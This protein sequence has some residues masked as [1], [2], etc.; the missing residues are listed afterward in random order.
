MKGSHIEGAVCI[1][2][3]QPDKFV[4]DQILLKQ[5]ELLIDNEQSQSGALESSL[6]DHEI[7]KRE[8][9]YGSVP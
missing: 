6:V 5:W 9:R 8:F 3:K 7:S 4:Q 1:S 2:C